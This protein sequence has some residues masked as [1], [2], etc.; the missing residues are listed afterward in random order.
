VTLREALDLL[1]LNE[2]T[3]EQSMLDVALQN[4]LEH[5]ELRHVL[6]VFEAYRKV[7]AFLN[8]TLNSQGDARVT[9]IDESI[10][11][12]LPMEV[13]QVSAPAA[14]NAASD[15]TSK[16]AANGSVKDSFE[17][18]LI[19]TGLF[20]A[21]DPKETAVPVTTSAPTLVSNP[22]AVV[23]T[24]RKGV[25]SSNAV[26]LMGLGALAFGAGA[27][28]I[29]PLLG[30]LT[31]PRASVLPSPPPIA[32]TQPQVAPPVIPTPPTPVA[33]PVATQSPVAAQPPIAATPPVTAPVPTPPT[34]T[35]PVAPQPVA[36]QP[37]PSPTP[38]VVT[39]RVTPPPAT[40]PQP[41]SVKPPVAATP[42]VQP[43]AAPSV[44]PKPATIKPAVK[45]TVKPVAP[46]AVVATRPTPSSQSTPRQS[47][48]RQFTPRQSIP[49]TVRVKRTPVRPAVTTRS[50]RS[51]QP[52]PVVAPVSNRVVNQRQFNR[53][54][55]NGAVLRYRSWALVPDSVRSLSA[56]RFRS[57]VFVSSSP[58]SLPDLPR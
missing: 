28:L 27:L 49:R 38:P 24:S 34:P 52:L 12:E 45:P 46:P 17:N 31:G 3:L 18:D 19:E 41:S 36:A 22:P 55:R 44:K 6:R 8:P 53:W 56:A 57:A 13:A 51:V 29:G 16:R 39:P 25:N 20:D 42:P 50:P 2:R 54:D 47:T 30:R 1:E 26:L 58:A 5:T 11:G 35:Q 9:I 10:P 15:W 43:S 33:P 14:W 7:N 23:A 21:I 48:P 4:R 37:T 32:V 40:T